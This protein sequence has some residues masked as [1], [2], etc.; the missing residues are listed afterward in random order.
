ML[1]SDHWPGRGVR[2]WPGVRPPGPRG[3]AGP[4]RTATLASTLA[5]IVGLAL[6]TAAHAQNPVP[7][8]V[9]A[10]GTELTVGGSV[11]ALFST[12]SVED[13][14][15]PVLWELRQVRL[16]LRI[17]AH[18]GLISARLQ[19]EFAGSQVTLKNAYVTLDLGPAA[20]LQ[21]GQARKP[22]GVKMS[23]TRRLFIERSARI[24]GLPHPMEHDNLINRL[25]YANHDIGVQLLGRPAGAPLGLDYAIGV[26]NGPAI[27]SVAGET[28][29]QLSGRVTIEPIRRL[30]LGAGVSRRHFADLDGEGAGQ[31]AGI[32][33]AVDAEYGT[34]APGLHLAAEFASGAADP[35]VAGGDRFKAISVWGG[36][37][38]QEIRAAV[39]LWIE[40]VMRFSYGD[41]EEVD[42]TASHR[43]LFITP[44]LNIYFNPLNRLML[45]YE[46]W[47]PEGGTAEGSI[48]AKLQVAF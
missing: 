42:R 37:R 43:G 48:K 18:E 11:Q 41:V 44:G 7:T 47:H 17:R 21:V 25:G 38:T 16:D 23:S 14:A 32:A 34:Y 5:L 6:P 31:K 28:S 20:R 9:A 27:G 39:P 15:E 36:Y 22:F 13:A 33:W 24:R 35:V 29:Y 1:D 4:G 10:G 26:F 45:N 19:P 12:T 46:R 3:L 40:P 30:R 8:P 2:A